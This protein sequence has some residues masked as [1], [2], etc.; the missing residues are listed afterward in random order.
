MEN[1]AAA[2]RATLESEARRFS[3][4]FRASLAQQSDQAVA[5]AQQELALQAEASRH[6]LQ[7]QGELQ[8][9]DVR[10]AVTLLGNQA[11][12]EYRKRLE[13]ASD[14]WLSATVLKLNEESKERIESLAKTAESRLRE[15]FGTVFAS[16]GE[17]LRH[18]LLEAV[19][20]ACQ[21]ARRNRVR[22]TAAS[23]CGIRIEVERPRSPQFPKR[24]TR[25]VLSRYSIFFWLASQ[26]RQYLSPLS[27]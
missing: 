7:M 14:S 16:V 1:H 3:S 11:I 6:D 24:Q 5:R 23:G 27:R 20:A 19:H 12:D 2:I 15:T 13:D 25:F 8:A 17:T 21:S 18:R 9:S 4:E 10:Q 22:K 26:R